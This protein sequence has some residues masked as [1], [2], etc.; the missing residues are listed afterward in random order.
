MKQKYADEI[1]EWLNGFE[2]NE[3]IDNNREKFKDYDNKEIYGDK[4]KDLL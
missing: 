3:N 2:K 4:G 1:D